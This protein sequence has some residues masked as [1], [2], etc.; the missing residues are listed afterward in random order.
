MTTTAPLARIALDYYPTPPSVVHAILHHL[1]HARTVLDP[2]CG[3]G[4]ILSE[5]PATDRLGIE[6]DGARAEEALRVGH[7]V[8]AGDAL[9]EHWPHA[10]LAIFNPPFKHALAFAELG[11]GWRGRDERRTVAMLARLTFIE[12]A[13]RAPFHEAN[14][15]D[16]YVFSSR[17]RFRGDTKGTD[18]VTVAWFV[19]GPGRGGKWSVL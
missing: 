12:S 13:A 7:G 6:L 1:P 18:A 4:E 9:T 14:P 2:C 10:E 8:I 16:V 11:V 19:W 15:S 17:P 3:V 5:V